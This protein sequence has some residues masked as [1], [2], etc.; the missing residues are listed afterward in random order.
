MRC[1]QARDIILAG[2][3]EA[4]SQETRRALAGH[5]SECEACSQVRR[6]AEGLRQ[7]AETWVD[8]PVPRWERLPLSF[9]RPVRTSLW[10]TWAPAVAC[11]FMAVLVLFRV[12]IT[13]DG[14]GF[15][16]GFGSSVQQQTG[17]DQAT[18]TFVNT[19][20]DTMQADT[21]AEMEVLLGR[22]R[23][24]QDN[25]FEGLITDLS[26]L[27][28][29]ERQSDLK[30]L[31]EKWQDQR[32]EDF[33]TVESRLNYMLNRQRRNAS[34]LYQLASYVNQSPKYENRERR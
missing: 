9:Q 21:V 26:D 25:Y 4:L 1:E 17:A 8:E 2:K 24:D 5:L 31:A 14:K 13:S 18:R 6:T 19:A 7:V 34:N 29:R 30:V 16:I 3:N 15:T 12:E 28:R 33:F 23:K 10:L 11:L 20:L 27:N 22:F 32:R